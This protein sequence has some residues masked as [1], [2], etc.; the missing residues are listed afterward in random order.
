[1]LLLLKRLD[2]SLKDSDDIALV[3]RNEVIEQ[4]DA[5]VGRTRQRCKQAGHRQMVGR[6]VAQV[7][8]CSQHGSLHTPG[9]RFFAIGMFA[10]PFFVVSITAP[11]PSFLDELD[12]VSKELNSCFFG[13][14]G[15]SDAACQN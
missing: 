9:A 7:V 11:A 5:S 15:F 6:S 4:N 12:R 10:I 1:M 3:V 14:H 8:R 2:R 13:S